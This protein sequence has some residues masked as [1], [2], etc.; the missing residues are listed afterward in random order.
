M[1]TGLGQNG[2]NFPG[3]IGHGLPFCLLGQHHI[4][5]VRVAGDQNLPPLHRLSGRAKRRA[6][7]DQKTFEDPVPG[8][9]K[10]CD[11]GFLRLHGRGG[12]LFRHGDHRHAAAGID[13]R[14]FEFRDG[15]EQGVFDLFAADGPAVSAEGKAAV[16]R[17]RQNLPGGYGLVAA[18][19]DKKNPCGEK[20]LG[21]EQK[22]QPQQQNRPAGKGA[23]AP[24]YPL[25]PQNRQLLSPPVRQAFQL[26]E[27]AGGHPEPES[28]GI[29]RQDIPQDD[30]CP[31]NGVHGPGAVGG[32]QFRLQTAFQRAPQLHGRLLHSWM[33]ST[34]PETTS[35]P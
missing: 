24:V 12:L 14:P 10:A 22:Q 18:D 17:R 28:E 5:A 29:L 25:P 15:A 9:R 21:T 23:K 34:A 33:L 30:A 27:A 11:A 7:G 6:P 26:P 4:S 3:R 32:K 35:C 2:L 13:P 16:L 20:Q 8:S 31:G 1:E 19:P